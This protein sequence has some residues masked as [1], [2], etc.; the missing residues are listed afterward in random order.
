MRM[1]ISFN[2]FDYIYIELAGSEYK[3]LS[4]MPDYNKAIMELAAKT[5]KK[6]E[7]AAPGTL[8][9]S[10]ATEQDK[11]VFVERTFPVYTFT[12]CGID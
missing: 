1:F 11:E 4:S 9:V 10:L 6:A 2:E 5:A 3:T 7:K 12:N 8:K